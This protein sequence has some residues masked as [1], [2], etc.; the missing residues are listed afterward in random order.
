MHHG[1]WY[2]V[3]LEFSLDWNRDG[4]L[5]QKTWV[6]STCGPESAG[7]VSQLGWR[8][9]SSLPC[10]NT[11]HLFKI[12]S[13]RWSGIFKLQWAGA[14]ELENW[15]TELVQ[16]I[17]P[18]CYTFRFCLVPLASEISVL[19]LSKDNHIQV[20][21]RPTF[22]VLEGWSGMIQINGADFPLFHLTCTV[23]TSSG[24]PQLTDVETQSQGMMV[25]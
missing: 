14:S 16:H 20:G 15:I 17:L 21:R 24:T 19:S 6:L 18:L 12:K 9:T 11:S 13:S 5:K 7:L 3:S 10:K 4:C 8:V 23:E 1:L 22:G 25:P 2:L